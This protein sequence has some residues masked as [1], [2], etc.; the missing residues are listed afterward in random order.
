M[1]I[2]EVTQ[3]IDGVLTGD[4]VQHRAEVD[5]KLKQVSAQADT[6]VLAD[7]DVN[8]LLLEWVKT[9]RPDEPVHVWLMAEDYAHITLRH[10]RD[11][12]PVQMAL[13]LA[14]DGPQRVCVD[15]KEQAA[16]LHSA[17]QDKYPDSQGLLITADTTGQPAVRAFMRNPSQECTRYGFVVYSPSISSGVSI[18]TP[19]FT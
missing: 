6:L 10:H 2:D 9:T 3:V 5:T 19:Y 14:D 16:T 1:F 12:K 4:H 13:E 7:A 18:E 8:D 15:S 11:G 17:L